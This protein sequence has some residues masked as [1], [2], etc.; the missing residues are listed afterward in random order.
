MTGSSRRIAI[1]AAAVLCLSASACATHKAT[2]SGGVTTVAGGSGVD[3]SGPGGN[4]VPGSSIGAGATPQAGGTATGGTAAGGSTGGGT[5]TGGSG[6][7]PHPGHSSAAP[8]PPGPLVIKAVV[9][10][11]PSIVTT[12]C[13]NTAPVHAVI[14]VSQGPINIS[15]EW[16]RGDGT[17]IMNKTATFTHAGQQSLNVY[18]DY[19]F[20][21]TAQATYTDTIVILGQAYDATHNFVRYTVTCVPYVSMKGPLPNHGLCPTVP[22]FHAQLNAWGPTVISYQWHFSDNTT[23]VMQFVPMPAGFSEKDIST[24]A[25]QVAARSL[26]AWI[27]ITS[28][29]GSTSKRSTFTCDTAN[30]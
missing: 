25:K 1:I 8:A 23:G 2:G 20:A 28:T 29:N 3:S 15:Y 4:P 27:V 9:E 18:D 13:P 12:N 19:D 21:S 24:S 14:S 6:S 26:A 10:Q 16:V 17:A 11:L 7:T 22:T 30:Q 5:T